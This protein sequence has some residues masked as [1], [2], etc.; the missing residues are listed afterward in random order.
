MNVKHL[1]TSGAIVVFSKTWCGYCSAVKRLLAS[2]APNVQMITIELDDRRTHT[3]LLPF[4][5]MATVPLTRRSRV[6]FFTADGAQLQAELS[7]MTGVRTVPQVFIHGKFV[8]GCDDTQKLHSQGK[9]EPLI[10]NGAKAGL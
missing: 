3:F 1:A 10:H 7:A 4:F 8:G 2:V 5:F 9:L 6:L